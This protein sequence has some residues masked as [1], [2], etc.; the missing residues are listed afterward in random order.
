MDAANTGKGKV[1][2]IADDKGP[3][4]ILLYDKQG[5]YITPAYNETVSQQNKIFGK[6]S[7]LLYTKNGEFVIAA[8]D[9]HVL[10]YS[11]KETSVIF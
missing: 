8:S 2:T 10:I 3:Q 5:V 7:F 9:T 6:A 11:L 4:D 1:Y